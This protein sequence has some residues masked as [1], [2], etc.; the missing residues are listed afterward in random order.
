MADEIKEGGESQPQEGGKAPAR[1][2]RAVGATGKGGKSGAATTKS[3][4][5]KS[6]APGGA[7]GKGKDKGP[8]DA[9]DHTTKAVEG[10]PRLQEYYEKTIR[11]KLAKEFGL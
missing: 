3:G 8:A 9:V 11:S 6:S 10:T 2:E 4:G 1:E 5:G 7:S